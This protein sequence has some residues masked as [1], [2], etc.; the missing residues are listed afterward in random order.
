MTSSPLAPPLPNLVVAGVQRAGTT[1]LHY[2][3]DRHPEV[4]FPRSPQEIH[5]FDLQANYRRGVDW[6]RSLFHEWQGQPWVGQTSPLY[7]FDPAVPQRLLNTLEAPRVVVILRDPVRRAYSHYWLEVRYGWE[8]K[9][10]SQALDHEPQRISKGYDVFRHYSYVSRGLYWRQ[11]EHWL[12]WLPREHLLVILQEE[13]RA[14]P[15]AVMAQAAAFLDLDPEGFRAPRAE[16]HLNAAKLPRWPWLQRAARPFRER[17]GGA[18]ERFGYLVD[19]INLVEAR[20]PPLLEADRDRL[21]ETFR[22][23]VEK[24]EALLDRDLRRWGWLGE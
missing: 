6:Y 23:D 19:R 22:E 14:D 7:L 12:Q 16:T 1:S 8:S 3:L 24:L 13:L 18:G 10:F 15:E 17:F 20:Y 4:F 11:L 5:Y 2:L 9:P 21:R